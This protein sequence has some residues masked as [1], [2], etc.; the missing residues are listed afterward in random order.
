MAARR[1]VPH[2]GTWIRSAVI[3]EG[4][5]VSRAARLMGVG[6]PA[7]S[8]L[9]NGN[10]ALSAEM[11]ARLEATFGTPRKELMDMQA[12][13]E[14]EQ[15]SARN[16][17]ASARSFVPPFLGI[18]A[19]QIEEWVEHDAAARRRLSVLLRTLVNS[20]GRA[21]TLVDFPG[22]EDAERPGW[23]GRVDADEATPWIPLGKSGWEFG[24]NKRIEEKANKDFEKSVI[25]TSAE[26]RRIMTFVFVT[27]RRWNGK[28][29]WLDKAKAQGL[30][31]DVRVYDSSDLEQWIAES[32][33]A[34]AWFASET[35]M[36]HTSVRSLDQCWADWAGVAEP[37]LP[38]ALFGPAVAAK[39]KDMLP[40]LSRAP[41]G[42][43]ILVADSHEE[44]L[45]FL[46]Q[47]FG[48]A[49][50]EEMKALR[51]K[52]VVFDEA[53][54]LPKLALGSPTFIPVVHSREVERELG[55]FAHS[56]HSIVICPRNA[57]NADPHVTLEPP[58]Y[59]AFEKALEG[60]GLGRDEIARL[61]QE[62]GR[63]LTVLR[64]RRSKVPAIRTPKWAADHG[65]A[66]RLIP[67]MFAGTWHAA[68]VNDQ[69]GLELLA[70]RP[71]ADVEKDVQQLA[72]VDDPPVWSLG[73]HR[74]VISKIDLLNAIAPAVTTEDLERY[75][76]FATEIVLCE[77]DPALDLED[78][79]RWAAEVYGKK[80]EFS[81][82]FRQGICETLVLLAVHGRALFN[83]RIAVDTQAKAA[84][85]VR[86]L[87]TPLTTRRLEAND[88]ELSIYAE[89][90]PD[91]FLSILEYGLDHA[92]EE[93]LGLM[94]PVT[95]GLFGSPSRTGLLWA[96][97]ALAWNP[98]TLARAALVLARLA[99]VRIEDNWQNK[100]IESL[101]GIFRSWMPQTAGNLEARLALMRQI[102]RRHPS[103]AWEICV[104]QFGY[105]DQVGHE[106]HKPRWRSDGLGYGEA[107]RNEDI[108]RFRCEMVEM[109]L[110]WE[111]HSVETLGDLVERMAGLGDE[112][113][114]R[115]WDVIDEW[116][117][118]RATDA[119]KAELREKIRRSV[120]TRMAAKRARKSG[121]TAL[122]RK[123]QAVHAALEPVDLIDRHA[124]LFRDTWVDESADELEEEDFEP[125]KRGERIRNL[126]VEALTEVH[127]ARGVAGL[128]ELS[129]RGNGAWQ[130]GA[131]SATKV[132]S[133]DEI[134]DLVHRALREALESK[135]DAFRMKSLAAGAL[136]SI[137][138][139]ARRGRI[140]EALGQ[141]LP[142]DQK[143]HLFTLAPFRRIT[144]AIVDRLPEAGRTA[145]WQSVIPE[146]IHQA[147]DEN[148]E[149]V[150][151]LL[152][153]NRPGAAFSCARL[154]PEK[155][156]PEMLYRVLDGIATSADG[157]SNASDW[158][159]YHFGKA[160]KQ[161]SSCA[162][163]TL[164]QKAA[165][166]F[167]FLPLLARPWD[168]SGNKSGI[169]NLEL[170]IQENPEF[171][172]RLV[173]W[174]F[175]RKDGGSDPADVVV[176]EDRAR[177]L[178]E[179]S[180]RLLNSLRRLPGYDDAGQLR[181]ER[182]LQWVVSVRRRCA[183]LGRSDVCDH[184]IGELLAHAPVGDD[185]VWPCEP[186]REV[187]E[188]V[189]S[190]ALT[191]G[192]HMGVYNSRGVQWRGEGG[193]QERALAAKYR[194]WA[195]ALRFSHPFVAANLLDDLAETYEREAG[196]EDMEADIR[197]RL[198]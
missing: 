122:T 194:R 13:F 183:E 52:V 97:E 193:D 83:G 150:Q 158:Q 155:L 143:A 136:R 125:D 3:P 75:F 89:A 94:R 18:R 27:P 165:L 43:T 79:K 185:D 73:N 132:L 72:G 46:A 186:V 121:R 24:T 69:L 22:N 28:H 36:P 53:G 45:A 16:A 37:E 195:L 161:I 190:K 23:D 159:G 163:L 162:A 153:A 42:P 39:A 187:M 87:L 17:P 189:R 48:E 100:P 172:A 38:A 135:D 96:L 33:A 47:L 177:S 113:Q 31:N 86:R 4:M 152:E 128:L 20:T 58:G 51:D 147:D 109:A 108:M 154:Q 114:A 6:R 133:D 41:D 106:N 15:A 25:S 115:V 148:N 62:S 11:A 174:C 102:A 137:E 63:S 19:N 88:G 40:R 179:Q 103:I 181:A 64:R 49:G 188:E 21:L 111:N 66:S 110:D 59:E 91:A 192:A 116:A 105:R 84:E 81:N 123:A 140:L 12:A 70:N 65:T 68:N 160:F 29:A 129:L 127:A 196:M 34:Q 90:A 61:A 178:A 35:A 32:I 131:L 112:F 118:N 101:K 74:G 169:P 98:E 119:E 164:E 107:T 146:W 82:V 191:Q 93:V 57:A 167:K 144:W 139:D 10:A 138:D 171:F 76:E 168:K 126:R 5:S 180:Y 60:A 149:A 166:E 71:Y 182:L 156:E 67:I 151:R 95:D 99:E 92:P 54:A 9:L 124:W 142:E 173:A 1:P 85:T 77:D 44:A 130:V 141:A 8:N 2:P 198:R 56:M 117:R 50:G 80:R 78:S 197:R 175:R 176:P 26:D 120:L 184:C 134:G 157:E 7:L 145:Y 30:W 104:D 170:Y 55:R 14:V